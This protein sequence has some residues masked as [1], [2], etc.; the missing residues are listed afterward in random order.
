MNKIISKTVLVIFSILLFIKLLKIFKLYSNSDNKSTAKDNIDESDNGPSYRIIEI[1]CRET[2]RLSLIDHHKGNGYEI[3]D[4]ETI[5]QLINDGLLDTEFERDDL[6]ISIDGNETPKVYMYNPKDTPY[7]G[8]LEVR[9]YC[10]LQ[11]YEAKDGDVRLI[12]VKGEPN[13]G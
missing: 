3:P 5:E 8:N 7:Y 12:M 11:D 9:A 1:T 10:E 6:F 13:H 4:L 2:Q